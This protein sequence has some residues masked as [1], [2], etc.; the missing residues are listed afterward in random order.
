MQSHF[1]RRLE[2]L[3]IFKD[4]LFFVQK[5]FQTQEFEVRLVETA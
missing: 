4:W 1:K 3:E 2:N 5:N